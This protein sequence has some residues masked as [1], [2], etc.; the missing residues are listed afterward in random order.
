MSMPTLD[1]RLRHL[2]REKHNNTLEKQKAVGSM[3]FDDTALILPPEEKRKVVSIMSGSGMPIKD[4][5]FNDFVP[6]PNHPNGGYYGPVGIGSNFRKFLLHHPPHIDP[7]SALAGAYMVSFYSYRKDVN[8][9]LDYSDLHEMQEKY[10]LVTGIF[11]PEHFCQDLQIGLDLGWDGLRNKVL[12]YRAVHG[13]DKYPFYDGLL[14]MI[15][16]FQ[17]WIENNA[18]HALKLSEAEPDPEIAAHLRQLHDMNMRVAH[19]KPETFLEACQFIL[20]YQMGGRSFNSSGSLGRLDV[21]LEPY[22]QRDIAAGVLTDEEAVFILACQLVR[23]TAYI[24][25]G[26]YDEQGNDTTNPVSFLIL[27]AARRLKLPSNLGVCVGKGVNRELLRRS[28]EMQFQDKCGNPRFVG[29]DALVEGFAKNEGV[30]LKDARART[31]AGCHWMAI[32]G[33][34]YSLMDCVKI[35]FAVVLEIALKE[36]VQRYEAPSIDQILDVYETHLRLAVETLA[37]GFTFNY[38]NQI[39]NFPELHLDLMSYGPVELGLDASNGGVEKYLWCIDGAA[40]AVVADSLAAIERRVLKEKRYTYTELMRFLETDWAGP[41]GEKARLFMQSVERY[42]KGGT[43]ADELAVRLSEMFVKAVKS[44]RTPK[45]GYS[46][47]P[48]LFS[49]ANTLEFGEQVGAT[50]NG[51]KAGKPISHGANPNPGFRADGAATAMS[52]AIASVQCGLG[53]TV[54]MQLELEPSISADEGGVEAVMALIEDHFAKGGTLINL[55]VIDADTLRRAHENPE[56]FPELI[57]RVTGFSA[58]FKS[59]SPPFRQLVVDRI[60][61]KSVS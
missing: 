1:E 6:E 21:L 12:K 10:K 2:I 37:K 41:D 25:L 57:V 19:K 54:P 8:P 38:E 20:W 44:A 39:H 5:I 43:R 58:Y 45:Y 32:P 14:L 7:M 29:V 48:G 35:N 13:E 31:N 18:K 36:A 52:H 61:D 22:Y 56:L 33:R 16:G 17:G 42:G 40:L 50:A 3:D 28:V 26:G 9:D 59:L 27:E 53:N 4:V 46:M 23:D 30:T 11:A 15:D 47:I 55:N 24:Q 60:L 51:R 34:E 49:W